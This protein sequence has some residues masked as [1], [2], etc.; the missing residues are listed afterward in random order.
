MGDKVGLSL[1]SCYLGLLALAQG[2]PT[3]ARSYFRDGLTIAYESDIKTYSIYNLIGMAA[4][5][6]ME[7]KHAES[8]TLLAAS[9]SIAESLGLKIE[10]ELQEP[11]DVALAKARQTCSE[12]DFQSAWETGAKMDM[13]HAVQFAL[14]K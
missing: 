11:Y 5:F 2:Q 6:M 7:N 13:E 1:L 4:L 8:V 9:S 10:P 12:D 3:A 14:E